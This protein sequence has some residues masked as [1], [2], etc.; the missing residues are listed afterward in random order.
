MPDYPKTPELDKPGTLPK[1]DGIV[2]TIG[3]RNH[4]QLGY[5][6]V[7]TPD[8]GQHP[9]NK[10]AISPA[11]VDEQEIIDTYLI[12]SV[13]FQGEELLAKV[14][15]KTGAS[16]EAIARAIYSIARTAGVDLT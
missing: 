4:P 10:K 1:F 11:P 15:E 12:L 9:V 3:H 8:G 7:I 5:Y 13:D 6:E 16:Y 2:L 14:Q